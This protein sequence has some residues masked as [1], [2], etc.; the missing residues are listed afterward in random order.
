MSILLE[1]IISLINTSQC[2]IVVLNKSYRVIDLNKIAHCLLIEDQSYNWRQVLW[3][4]FCKDL[5][6]AKQG[7]CS[8]GDKNSGFRTSKVMKGLSNAISIEWKRVDFKEYLVLLGSMYCDYQKNA[9]SVN[10]IF[11]PFHGIISLLA[12]N[13]NTQEILGPILHRA[14]ESLSEHANLKSVDYRY[15]SVSPK[16]QR[17]LGVTDLK[18]IIGHPVDVLSDLPKKYIEQVHEVDEKA[19]Y[20][21]KTIT[22]ISGEP[23]I[24]AF[25]KVEQH[26]LNKIPLTDKENNVL[27]LLT[28]SVDASAIKDPCKVRQLYR[29]LYQSKDLAHE[30]F[31]AHYGLEQFK[32]PVTNSAISNREIDVLMCLSLHNNAKMVSNDLKITENTVRKYIDAIKMKM[33]CVSKLDV[34]EKFLSM[35]RLT[36]I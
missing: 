29:K 9:N 15:I 18:E 6:I 14:V 4:E 25:G 17:S 20:A 24:N 34:V 35:V 2:P 26:I 22:E 7:N 11:D 32:H 5:G 8:I 19:V 30:K 16:T 23:F 1:G 21:R 3:D 36:D 33:N 12:K 31:L 10:N 13:S 28:L 27:F